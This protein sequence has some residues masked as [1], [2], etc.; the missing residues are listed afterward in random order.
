VPVSHRGPGNF[1]FVFQEPD[2]RPFLA[3]K[4]AAL[5]VPVGPDRRRLVQGQSITLPDGRPLHPDEV[6]GPV[7]RGTKV[8][9]IGDAAR[10]DNLVEAVQ[11]ADA[12]II[13]ATYLGVD[14]EL[15][16]QFGHLTALEAAKLAREA[17]VGHLYLTHVSQRYSATAIQ[18]EASAVFPA[19]TLA[20]DLDRFVIKRSEDPE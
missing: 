5:G 12:L 9:Y 20:N 8:A 10:A 16:R 14:A 7:Q 1:G 19:T 3:D 4:A 15:A 11:G 18:E 2:R 17:Q 6:M 13:E